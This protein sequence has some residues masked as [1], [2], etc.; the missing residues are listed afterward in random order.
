MERS[1]SAAELQV[2]REEMDAADVRG[3]K[4]EQASLTHIDVRESKEPGM[5]LLS[6]VL[7]WFVIE[8]CD[9][10]PYQTTCYNVKPKQTLY[11]PHNRL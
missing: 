1:L 6:D 4:L 8:F 9:V 5:E 3:N 11:S 10:D 7:G 2:R